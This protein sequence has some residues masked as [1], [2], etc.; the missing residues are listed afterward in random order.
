M[1]EREPPISTHTE[2]LDPP[3]PPVRQRIA[4]GA[5]GIV[6][7]II[8]G[9]VR[10]GV[11]PNAITVAGFT[12]VAISCALILAEKWVLAWFVFT[13]GSLSDMLDGSVARLSGKATTFGAFLDSTL[14]RL[15]EGLVLGSIGIVFA[16]DGRHW[17][18]A[19]CF[20][21]LTASFLV[22]YTR[23]RAEGLGV[24]SNRGG[25]MSRVERLFLIGTGLF[26]G[27][28]DHFLEIAIYV[29]A[30]LTVLTVIQRVVYVWRELRSRDS[31]PPPG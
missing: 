25:L 28:I 6:D 1:T 11:G 5:R 7:P 10:R 24:D 23:A 29:L 27:W 17:A 22:S 4:D 3:P 19:A 26:F 16:R 13:V 12:L 18:L 31:P 8:R 9:L 21:A 20:A 2:N 15:A 14:D 30:V